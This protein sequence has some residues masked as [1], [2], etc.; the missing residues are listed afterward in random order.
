[1]SA[2]D[3]LRNEARALLTRLDQLS[4][5]SLT[6]PMTWAATVSDAAMHGMER[7]LEQAK[8]TLRTAVK[9]HIDWLHTAEKQRVS[10]EQAQTKYALLKLRFN[11]LLDQVDIFADVLA[12][13]SE[14][15]TGVWVAGLD[16]LAEDAL[17]LPV[18]LYEP[19]P[20]VCFLERGHG[21]A[22]RRARTRLPGG[23]LN[24][25]AV[26]QVPRERMVGSGIGASLIHEVGHQGAMLLHLV[27]S[28]RDDLRRAAAGDPANARSWKLY[29]Q[30]ISEI[31]ADVWAIGHLGIGATTGL[32]GVVGLPK[33][34]MFRLPEANA[35]H[36]FPWI[37]VA[38]SLAFGKA[39]FP[40]PQWQ[41]LEKLWHTLYPPT[42]LEPEMA[43][44]L[45]QLQRILPRFV[46]LVVGHRSKP[47]GNRRLMDILPVRTRQPGR[48]MQLF[49]RWQKQ[50][51]EWLKHPPSLVFAVVGQARAEGRLAPNVENQLLTRCLT[52]WAKQNRA[53][54]NPARVH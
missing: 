37:R 6:M 51:E 38:I 40:H 35:P 11:S 42:G 44:L 14:H 12:Q 25:V 43:T 50:P 16:A 30:W 15:R 2:Y 28:V 49:L 34:F 5:F 24:P 32:I 9:E 31:L 21:A 8:S 1:L 10:P 3:F 22:I 27:E 20:V 23:D 18:R 17:R 41:A 33:Y 47:M 39:L 48:L 7:H 45:K 53:P 36:P 29:D 26:I 46:Q 4:A 52:H 19:P 54:G 13:R